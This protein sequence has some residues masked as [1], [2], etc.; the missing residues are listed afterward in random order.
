LPYY[1]LYI[2]LYPFVQELN[3]KTPSKEENKEKMQRLTRH[4]EPM[5]STRRAKAESFR[6]HSPPTHNGEWKVRKLA[7]EIERRVQGEEDQRAKD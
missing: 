3:V 6:D 5:A 1:A 2:L 7:M 4:G